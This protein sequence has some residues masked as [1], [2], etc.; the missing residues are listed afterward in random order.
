MARMMCEPIEI[1]LKLMEF[2]EYY[3]F[4]AIYSMEKYTK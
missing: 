1:Q 4:S 3:E 2:T